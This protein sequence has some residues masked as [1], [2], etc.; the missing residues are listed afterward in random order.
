MGKVSLEV[1]QLSIECVE[2]TLDCYTQVARTLQADVMI[3]GEIT[4]G[5]GDGEFQLTVSLLDAKEKRFIKRAAKKFP[6]EDDA[7]YDMHRV[8]E[9]VTR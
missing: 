5:P 1:I 7:R 3:F 8:V 9:E 2:P 4:P 6:S